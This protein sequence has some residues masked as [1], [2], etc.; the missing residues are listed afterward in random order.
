MLA[1]SALGTLASL[2]ILAAICVAPARAATLQVYAT[3]ISAGGADL[4]FD[5]AGNM[6]VT[7]GSG[8]LGKLYKVAPGGGAA[9]PMTLTGPALFQPWGLATSPG[10]TL[11]LVDR[12][13]PTVANSGKIY[14]VSPT[15]VLTL[16]KGSL[17]GP[18][19]I[20][21]DPAGNLYVGLVSQNKVAKIT[22]G[23]VMTNYATGLGVAGE[24]VMQLSIDASGNIYAGVEQDMYKIAPGGSPVTKVISG[25]LSQAMGH[26]RWA[27]D[28]FIVA[29]F[30]F[31]QLKHWSAAY[32]LH[33][34]LNPAAGSCAVG[35]LSDGVSPGG[36]SMSQPTSMRLLAGT[37]YVA[38]Q[39]CHQVRA[40][41]VG[42]ITPARGRTWGQL[43]TLYR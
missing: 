22:P 18:F 41:D 21:F 12:G 36:A 7:G 23:G 40:F 10:G 16:F 39:G 32:G 2:V 25:G 28:N 26:V 27:S 37:V 5:G 31:H 20:V 42:D 4:E 24:Q 3:N 8:G 35:L 11:Y 34:L 9:T 19:S 38:D 6:Y 15:G 29:T 30:G 1:R 14:S 17:A 13:D 33:N 43:K